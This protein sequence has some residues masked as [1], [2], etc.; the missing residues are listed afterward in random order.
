MA[1]SGCD[2]PTNVYRRRKCG[3]KRAKVG[4]INLN[5]T[6]G[7]GVIT[8]RCSLVQFR[9]KV[10]PFVIDGVVRFAPEVFVHCILGDPFKDAGSVVPLLDC[11]STHP[12]PAPAAL[13][14]SE[15]GEP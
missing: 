2:N 4:K 11:G 13:Q 15:V 12:V 9:V 7:D 8:E 1:D 5:R 14:T 10:L 3:P 6:R